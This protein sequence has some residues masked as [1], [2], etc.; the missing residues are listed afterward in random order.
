MKRKSMSD[1]AGKT[2]I[3]TGGGSGIGRATAQLLA[4]RGARLVVADI[5]EDAARAVADEI[6]S[7]GGVAEPFHCDVEKEGDIIAMVAHAVA[8]F[9]G[10]HILHNNA[11]LVDLEVNIQDQNVLTID[12]SLWDRI[13]AI[14][15]RSVMLG[16]KHAI[17]EMIRVGGGAIVN[18]SSTYGVAA[19]ANLCAYGTSKAALIQLTR[20]V[21]VAFGRQG[22]R[23]NAVAPSL[24]ATPGVLELFPQELLDAN[25]NGA[26]MDL[27]VTPTD[28]AEAVAFLASDAARHI[29]GHLLPVDAGT[30]AHLSTAPAGRAYDEKMAAAAGGGE[31][32]VPQ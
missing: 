17:P 31:K 28:I 21:A 32:A 11:A 24:V 25:R 18:T 5:R 30:L 20:Y 4:Q 15:V 16:C 13:M 7:A 14:N 3:V 9:G 10:L 8:T 1:F 2:A 23:C 12:A 6:R 19:Y 29:T 26:A 22:I 27:L